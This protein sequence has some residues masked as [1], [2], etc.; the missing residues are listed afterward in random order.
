VVTNADQFSVRLD[1]RISDRSQLFARFNFN[2][3]YGPTTNPDQTTID[4]A[5]GIRYIDHQRNLV[6]TF[7]RTVSPA[8]CWN[9]RP[10]S[11]VPLLPSPPPT[12]P[13]LPSSSTTAPTSRS[14]RPAGTVISI[15]GNLFQARQNLSFTTA[16]HAFKA[17]G[18]MRLNR[19]TTYFGISPDGE[20]DFGGGTAYSPIDIPSQSGLHNIRVGDPLPDTL[21]SLLSGSP[22]VY[23]VAVAP[24]YFSGGAHIGAAAINRNAFAFFAQDTW[25]ISPRLVLD[26]GLRY[27]LYTPSPSA[28]REPPAWLFP[29]P[30]PASSNS[31]SSIRSRAIASISMAW[32]RASSWIGWQGAQIHLR[33]A[34]GITTIPPNLFQDN[35]LTG[36]NPFAVDP[37]LT[38]T[39]AAPI[40]YGFQITSN[41]LP[42]VYTPEG[43]NI[44]A[45]GTKAVPAN[46]VM[47]LNRYQQD[48]AALSPAHQI[49][50]LTINCIDP[51]FGN[52]YLQTWTLG[53][54]RHFGNLVADATYIGTAAAK[55]ARQS[56]FNGY[57]GAGPSFAPYTQFD[58]A[59]NIIGGFGTEN[60]I[61]ATAHSSYHALQ[62]S[63][64]GTVPMAALASRPATPG[65]NRSTKP[66][67]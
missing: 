6:V 57:N 11:P 15:Y 62:T 34:G 27:E 4:P 24:P 51:A 65:Q 3:L 31:S 32:D 2:N 21:S 5:F 43:Q 37:R 41:E 67:P 46:T 42:L 58:Q 44:F 1:H 14:I 54:E 33:A 29:T 61:T 60:V 10:V 39:A 45:N 9:P 49:T 26:Y 19:D 63:L 53:L 55:L 7:T 12:S 17:G 36:S 23:T 38:S 28:P 30:P 20:Y 8:W 22:F 66:V 40:P 50:P 64:Q 52:A 25:K 16:S 18:E 13:T 47:D 56:F 48:L 59:G 35:S